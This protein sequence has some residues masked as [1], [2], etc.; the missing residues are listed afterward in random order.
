MLAACPEPDIL[1]NN[2]GGPPPGDFRDLDEEDWLNGMVPNMLTPI[3]LIKATVDGMAKRGFGRIV[4]ITSRSRENAALSPA[5]VERRA[6]RPDRLHCRPAAPGREKQCHHQ[7]PAAGAIRD[8]TADG[9]DAE[10]RGRR[11]NIL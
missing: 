11:G 2:A 6:R 3:M 1:I 7:Q 8:R 4:N 10:T 5:A 9:A